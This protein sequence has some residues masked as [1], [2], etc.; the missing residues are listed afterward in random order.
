MSARGSQRAARQRVL[1]CW[2]SDP[3][4][5]RTEDRSKDPRRAVPCDIP[6]EGRSRR[7]S[8]PGAAERVRTGRRSQIARPP[9]RRGRW[10]LSSRSRLVEKNNSSQSY[11]S[12]P[13][14]LVN[15]KRTHASAADDAHDGRYSQLKKDE[16]QPASGVI[17]RASEHAR[18]VP[19][20]VSACRVG[21]PLSSKSER[22]D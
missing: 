11:Y 17:E 16:R 18:H 3:R 21:R 22:H 9:G 1:P 4:Q 8:V 19:G 10:P 15:N 13:S 20:R 2:T 5:R 6:E 7:A 12:E 14:L